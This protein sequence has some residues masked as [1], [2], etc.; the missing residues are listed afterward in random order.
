LFSAFSNPFFF[1]NSFRICMD[2]YIM[3]ITRFED[4]MGG[5]RQEMDGISGTGG[6]Y[7]VMGCG[8]VHSV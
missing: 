1:V 4:G 7:T 5:G 3:L 8:H 2:D 6:V